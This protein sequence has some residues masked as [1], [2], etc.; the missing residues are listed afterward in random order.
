MKQ[1]TLFFFFG[2]GGGGKG[3]GEKGGGR[4]CNFSCESCDKP[5][6]VSFCK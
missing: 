2:G 1:L 3:V 5:N 4:G 6:I